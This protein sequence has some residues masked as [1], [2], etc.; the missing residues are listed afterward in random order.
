MRGIIPEGWKKQDERGRKKEEDNCSGV[1]L[2]NKKPGFSPS[3]ETWF[4]M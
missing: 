2:R 3:A 1:L 4:L